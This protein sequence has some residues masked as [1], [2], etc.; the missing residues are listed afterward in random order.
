MRQ[1]PHSANVDC[2]Q[3]ETESGKKHAYRQSSWIRNPHA[4]STALHANL[5]FL[6]II[7]NRLAVG[8]YHRSSGLVVRS[9]RR[10]H[11]SRPCDP[12]LPALPSSVLCSA[13]TPALP[14]CAPRAPVDRDGAASASGERLQAPVPAAEAAADCGRKI[15][16]HTAAERCCYHGIG[17]GNSLKKQ[18]PSKSNPRQN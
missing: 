18:T 1:Q 12:S 2:L 3:Q 10:K 8:I 16:G 17:V 5:A 9:P 15:S 13:A 6:N 7:R 14:V 4:Y 11:A